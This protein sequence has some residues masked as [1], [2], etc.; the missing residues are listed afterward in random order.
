MKK[1]TILRSLTI[2]LLVI[3]VFSIVLVGC[4]E[5][6]TTE[7]SPESTDKSAESG[8]SGTIDVVGSTSVQPLAEELA[9]AFKEKES[10]VTV[11]IQGVGSTAGVKAAHDGTADIGTAS[12][13][14]KEEEKGWGLK[15]V[16]IALDGIAVIVHPNNKLEDLTAEQV[17]KIFKGEITN[18]KDVGG[19]DKEILVVSREEGSGTRGAFEEIME[20]EDELIADAL[21]AGSNGEVKQNVSQKEDSIGYL[22]LGIVDDTV[23]K[24]K[25]DGAECT[26]ET[27]KAG[28]YPVQRP[29]LMLTQDGKE[30]DLV[31][32]FLDFILSEEGQKVVSGE[33]ISV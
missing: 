2:I 9:N 17:T 18:W 12:R 13:N 32:A 24:V 7:N 5:E 6:T 3:A 20:F 30:S 21:I 1:Y 28:N 19:E 29:F 22:S 8:L 15:E 14:L 16:T 26:V 25:V 4:K 27:I 31:K 33:Y 23:K 10:G 11:N